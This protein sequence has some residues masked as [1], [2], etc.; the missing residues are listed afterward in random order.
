MSGLADRQ[1]NDGQR[2][3][4]GG[5]GREHAAVRDEQVVG[6]EHPSP[7]VTDAVAFVTSSAVFTDAVALANTVA[8]A[9]SSAAAT[10]CRANPC[11]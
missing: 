1:R 11:P 8:F 3:I 4:G 6:S 10:S 2:G 9:V 5:G 7:A